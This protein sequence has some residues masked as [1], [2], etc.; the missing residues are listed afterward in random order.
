MSTSM[1]ELKLDPMSTDFDPVQV[2]DD[3]ETGDEGR[4][5]DDTP[6]TE[7]DEE[8][9]PTQSSFFQEE[10]LALELFQWDSFTIM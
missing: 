8:L 6:V 5:P 10:R 9:P 7:S 1:L 4:L 2:P 3:M